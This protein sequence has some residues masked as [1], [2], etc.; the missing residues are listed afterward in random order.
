MA[1][2]KNEMV[3]P[4]TGEI[5]DTMKVVKETDEFTVYQ[6]KDGK[7]LRKAKFKDYNSVKVE[8]KKDKIWLMNL[9]EN[10]EETGQGLK[11]NIGAEIEIQDII[12]RKYDKVNEDTGQVEYGVLTYLITPEKDAYVTSSKSV[13]FSIIN[14]F[15]M[16]G[17]PH[18]EEWENITVKVY[19]KKE[20]NGK[21]VKI[22]VIG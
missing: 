21:A 4:E 15:K 10:D 2:T 12:T 5:L 22:R 16:F 18:N 17:H 20:Q 14:I 8:S 19:D 7:F 3:N 9:I 13:Y 1:E 6:D 11:D